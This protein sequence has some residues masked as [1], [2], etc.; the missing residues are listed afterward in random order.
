MK[1][2][3]ADYAPLPAAEEDLESPFRGASPGSSVSGVHG[4]HRRK[5]LTLLPLI[6]LIFFE[7]SGGPFGTEVRLVFSCSGFPC[8][9]L[10]CLRVPRV[11]PTVCR[12][13]TEA[14]SI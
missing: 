4:G 6:A 3:T 5:P 13:R 9:H 14:T 10:Q 8:C 2:N 1:Q 11:P 12:T 7:V